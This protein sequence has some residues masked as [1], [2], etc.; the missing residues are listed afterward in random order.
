MLQAIAHS[1]IASML[2]SLIGES[3]EVQGSRA[4]KHMA[5]VGSMAGIM[6]AVLLANAALV[7]VYL[8]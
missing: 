1:W 3:Y 8:S 5:A 4:T 7:H 2:F 6:L